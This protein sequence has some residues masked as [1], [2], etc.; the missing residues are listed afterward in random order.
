M[1]E[2]AAGGV[3]TRGD[4][5]PMQAPFTF[6]AIIILVIASFWWNDRNNHFRR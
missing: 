4:E 5:K 2:L 3:L 6:G 1:G